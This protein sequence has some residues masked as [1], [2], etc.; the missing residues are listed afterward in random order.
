MAQVLRTLLAEATL[1]GVTGQVKIERR[2]FKKTRTTS[3]TE[4]DASLFVP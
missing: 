2:L 1:G 3:L 4:H